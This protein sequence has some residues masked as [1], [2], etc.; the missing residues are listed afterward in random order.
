MHQLKIIALSIILLVLSGCE[1]LQP[2][3][4]QTNEVAQEPLSYIFNGASKPTPLQFGAYRNSGV[5]NG[6]LNNWGIRIMK[7][8]DGMLV[9]KFLDNGTAESINEYAVKMTTSGDSITL[10]PYKH[11]IHQDGLILPMPVPEFNENDLYQF[12]AATRHTF[13]FEVNS[14]YPSE[15]VNANFKRLLSQNSLESF[16]SG[17]EKIFANSYFLKT[18]NAE[19]KIEVKTFPYRNGSKCAINILY[20]TNL[21]SDKQIKLGDIEN[22]IKARIIE[23]INA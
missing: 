22:E 5:N 9:T 12:L 18:A 15:S 2:I 13:H 14:D 8:H 1:G 17:S 16:N 4:N 6:V 10:T 3:K 21:P 19:A 23:I 7:S 20:I 11:R